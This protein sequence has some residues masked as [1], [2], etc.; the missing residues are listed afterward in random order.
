MSLLIVWRI[1]YLYYIRRPDDSIKMDNQDA[2]LESGRNAQLWL[3]EHGNYLYRF[4]FSR[5]RDRAAA[6]DLV[7]DTLLTAINRLDTF[8]GRS[9]MRTWLAGI[10]RF[11][12][13]EYLR[14][15]SR[16]TLYSHQEESGDD[17]AG[18]FDRLQLWNKTF[19][20]WADDPDQCFE[21]KEFL[22]QLQG[23]LSKLKDKQRLAF[24][25]TVV[26][27][28][29]SSAVCEALGVKENN[30]F[31]LLYRAR[32]RLRGCLETNWVESKD[33]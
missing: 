27:E 9:S 7:Q 1:K 30:L 2:A 6:E 32:M 20:N 5:V 22:A 17:S 11:K 14:R 23:C 3:E 26:D 18:N 8:E 25:L 12:L 4:A 29:E 33:E 28:N 31:V 15:S 10:L 13:M 21:S 16:E 24:L 19:A